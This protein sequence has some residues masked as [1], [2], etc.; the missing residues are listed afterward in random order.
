MWTRRGLAA[1]GF[2]AA[3]GLVKAP[4][5]EAARTPIPKVVYHL[6]ELERVGVVLR[7]IE[8]HYAG[9]DEKPIAIALVVHGGALSAFWQASVSRDVAGGFA[10]LVETGLSSYACSNTLRA[11]GK[12]HA[13]LLEGFDPAECVGVVKLAQLQGESYAYIRP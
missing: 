4:G 3:L 11:Q 1:P 6:N 5:A 9:M 12:T 7:S 8:N 2:L 10:D 13:D